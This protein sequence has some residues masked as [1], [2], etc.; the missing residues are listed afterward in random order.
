MPA[1][2]RSHGLCQAAAA[3]PCN[4]WFFGLRRNEKHCREA[5]LR[6]LGG[7][8]VPWLLTKKLCRHLEW[9]LSFN[10]SYR[11]QVVAHFVWTTGAARGRVARITGLGQLAC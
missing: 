9:H 7:A 5:D 10:P 11:V 3:R 8:K 4:C 2:L 6:G 1:L